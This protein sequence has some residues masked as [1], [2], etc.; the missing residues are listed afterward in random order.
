M[1][2]RQLVTSAVP[3]AVVAAAFSAS[4]AAGPQAG[5]PGQDMAMHGMTAS[6]TMTKAQK[7]ASAISAGPS[8]IAGKAAILDW[9]AGE[10]QKPEVL[11][12]GTNGWTCLPDMPDSKGNDPMC[13]DATWM[14]W[15]D[16]YLAHK[17]PQIAGVGIA[18]MFAPGGAWGSNSDPYAQTET[19][20]N[21]W[22]H[23]PPHMMILVPDP[24]SLASLPTD[25]GNG[26]PYV[27]WAGTPY[28]HIMAPVA[29]ATGSMTMK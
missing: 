15:F 26:G 27:M 4:L 6:S 12:A 24:K 29:P 23:H 16:A 17:T 13:V 21:H 8:N 2:I 22:A 10:G 19:A 3:A 5:K 11:R 14:K 25:P 20:G 18:Y 28:A 9:P 1:F 7:I